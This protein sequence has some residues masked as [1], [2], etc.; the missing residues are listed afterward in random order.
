MPGELITSVMIGTKE[1]RKD[2]SS[3]RRE[4]WIITK[5]GRMDHH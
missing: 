3:L 1:G 4:G 5:E 2:G